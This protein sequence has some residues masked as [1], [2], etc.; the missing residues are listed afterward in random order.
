MAY[1]G[2]DTA[3]YRTVSRDGSRSRSRCGR[4]ATSS[5]V[6]MQL[7]IWTGSMATP[8]VRS[9]HPAAASRSA[10]PPTARGY[11]ADE[12]PAAARAAVTMSGTG[13]IGVPTDRSTIP[14]GAASARRLS[15][16]SRA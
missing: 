13:S 7:T 4:E 10:G 9:N 2:Y 12:G 8:K 5:L 6:P 11:P 16:S 15:A 1:V 3:G 14:P